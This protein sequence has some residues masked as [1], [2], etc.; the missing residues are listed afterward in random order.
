MVYKEN[1]VSYNN[2]IGPNSKSSL[3][4]AKRDQSG[5]SSSIRLRI[6]LFH[7]WTP[8]EDRMAYFISSPWRPH[9]HKFTIVEVT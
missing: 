6:T 9:L 4:T 7:S 5:D 1:K 2:Q 8:I 3:N